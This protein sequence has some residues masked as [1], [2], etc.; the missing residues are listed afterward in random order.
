MLNKTKLHNATRRGQKVDKSKFVDVWEFE[1]SV[2]PML[3]GKSESDRKEFITALLKAAEADYR[4]T[5]VNK[6]PLGVENT[7]RRLSITCPRRSVD[8]PDPIGLEWKG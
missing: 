8:D 1:L 6:P 3:R 4:K 7:S 2:P 5:R